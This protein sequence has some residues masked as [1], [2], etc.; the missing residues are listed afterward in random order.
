M[1]RLGAVPSAKGEEFIRHQ[2]LLVPADSVSDPV[3]EEAAALRGGLAGARELVAVQCED[4]WVRRAQQVE[5]SIAMADLEEQAAAAERQRRERA[6]DSQEAE[7][8]AALYRR[9]S[10][11]G[12]RARLRAQIEGSA[13]MRALRIVNVRKVALI[14]GLPVLAAFAAWSTTGVQAG[15]VRLLDLRTGSPAWW[16]SWA[17]E[18]AL[19]TV[20]ALIIVGRAVLR[21]SGGDT[22]WRATA[23]EWAALGLSLALNILGG[24][25][26][27]WDGLTGAL[28]HSIGP[29]GAAGTAFLIGLFDSYVT[30]A[31]PWDGAPRLADLDELAV[32]VPGSTTVAAV[33]MA[34]PGRGVTG[35][36]RPHPVPVAGTAAPAPK[37]VPGRG[38]TGPGR[39]RPVPMAGTHQRA[40]A[41]RTGAGERAGAVSVP[42]SAKAAARAFWDAETAAGRV[43]TGADL[44]RAAGKDNDDTGVFRRYARD[45]AA[46]QIREGERDAAAS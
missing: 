41:G 9:A 8:L 36:G 32:P 37:A 16:A 2:G 10:K 29:L 39:P 43:P 19:I 12:A 5:H 13:E 14:A 25:H 31:R 6:R 4:A 34:V 46:E 26:G 33:P 28:P 21:S 17:M 15:V 23:A 1:S 11:S 42:G 20:V 18:P 44:A 45:W 35:S 27:T 22:D 38:A 3:A 30:A 40:L 24:W 7:A